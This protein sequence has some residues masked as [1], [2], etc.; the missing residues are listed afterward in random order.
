M[1]KSSNLAT[2]CHIFDENTLNFCVKKAKMVFPL[3]FLIFEF[4]LSFFHI[5]N[6]CAAKSLHLHLLKLNIL[7]FGTTNALLGYFVIIKISVLKLVLLQN[8]RQKSKSLNLQL[9][10]SYFGIFGLVFKS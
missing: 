7:K 4:F 8:L 6:C 3:L 2:T 9:K 1:C 5:W 10:M